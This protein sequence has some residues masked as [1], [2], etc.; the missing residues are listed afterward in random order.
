MP[1]SFSASFPVT[2]YSFCGFAFVLKVLILLWAIGK[3]FLA[4]RAC[5]DGKQ[6]LCGPFW[7]GLVTRLSAFA[8]G[9]HGSSGSPWQSHIPVFSPGNYPWALPG[10]IPPVPCTL[11]SRN[12]FSA[13]NQS[14]LPARAPTP[15]PSGQQKAIFEDWKSPEDF[16][17]T[18]LSKDPSP[19]NM[20]DDI[21]KET[22]QVN[23]SLRYA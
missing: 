7:W 9:R 4:G 22:L 8:R 18:P 15:F 19:N 23:K 5:G 2:L 1:L 14:I 17:V 6:K 20:S 16:P 3:F 13:C 11:P 21:K 12:R 10:A